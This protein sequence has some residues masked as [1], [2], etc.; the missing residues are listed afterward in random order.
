VASTGITFVPKFM[1]IHPVA[2][3][4]QHADTHDRNYA[5]TGRAPRREL[6]LLCVERALQMVEDGS[7][8][9]ALIA[10]Y[11]GHRVIILQQEC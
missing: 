4:L 3:G 11:L 5:S 10:S 8:S 1:K 6:V 9:V 2:L 7:C